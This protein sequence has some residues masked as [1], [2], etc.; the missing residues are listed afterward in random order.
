MSKIICVLYPDPVDGYP[1]SYVRDDLPKLT[2]YPGGQTLPTPRNRLRSGHLLGSVSGE[3][4]LRK[5]I[6]SQGY[7]LIVTT[8]TVPTRYSSVSFPMRKS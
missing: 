5:F 6:E 3:L 4:G 1:K 7:E 2:H 8:R